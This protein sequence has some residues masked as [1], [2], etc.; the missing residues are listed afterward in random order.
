MIRGTAQNPDVFFQ[1]REAINS[2]YFAC[3][4]V[5]QNVIDQFVDL[6]GRNYHLFDYVG[7]P[8]AE[9]V[10]ALMGSGAETAQETVEHLVAR[11]EKGRSTE[12]PPVPAVLPR[13]LRRSPAAY[14][15]DYCRLG[16]NE[17]AGGRRRTAPHGHCRGFQRGDER[18]QPQCSATRVRWT[19][20]SLLQ[21]VHSRHGQGRVP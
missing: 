20:R 7:A 3:P 11:G 13:A 15:Q 9:R 14:G 10:I 19:L 4:T 12:S 16:S 21:R 6:V 5:M 18:R 1:A 17:R 8:D 2:Y